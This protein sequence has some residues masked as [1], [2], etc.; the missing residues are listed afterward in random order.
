M[1]VIGNEYY[2]IAHNDRTGQRQAHSQV[3]ALGLAASL[4]AELM[5]LGYVIVREG[6]ALYASGPDQY[7]PPECPLQREVLAALQ[8]RPAEHD[9]GLWLDLL[10]AEAVVDVAKRLERA[11]MLVMVKRRGVL[12]GRETYQ[13]R[14]TNTAFWASIRLAN[15]LKDRA[16]LT[17]QDAV[18]AMV[19]Q[20]TGLMPRVLWDKESNH[21]A[22]SATVNALMMADPTLPVPDT[23]RVLA[24]RTEAAAG[25]VVLTRRG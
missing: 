3:V 20:V 7:S 14:D 4:L 23:F 16:A 13:P 22:G 19:V 2:L 10:A 5:I 1:I 21:V 25:S 17:L 12:G 8:S 9:L 18:L 24:Q 11:G 15:S 6:G